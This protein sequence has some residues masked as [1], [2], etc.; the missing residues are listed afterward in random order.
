MLKGFLDR[1]TTP[2]GFTVS[3]GKKR[4][5]P[6]KG[7]EVS[8]L[9][10]DWIVSPIT[11]D[12]A[13]RQGGIRLRARARDLARNNSHIKQFLSLLAANVI[14]P[15]G[16]RLQA[17]VKNNNKE[18]LKPINDKIE[19]AWIDWSFRPTTDKRGTLKKLSRLLIKTLAKDGEVFVRMV[20]GFEGNKYLFALQPIDASQIDYEFNRPARP[21]H[22]EIRL[23]IEVDAWGAAVAYHIATT[24]EPDNLMRRFERIP[25]DKI[26]HIYDPEEI[27]QTRG[28]TWLNS[29]M[30]PIKMLEG[31]AEAELVA[32]R[33]AA[34]KM[35]FIQSKSGEEGEFVAPGPEEESAEPVE[36]EL[37]ASPGVI[38]QLPPGLEFQ[39]W[40]PTHPTSAFSE[41]MKGQLRMM[42]SGLHTSYNALASDLEGVNFSSLRSGLLIERDIWKTI[43]DWWSDEFLSIVYAKWL[44]AA[45]L[46][47][48]LVLDSRD[49]KKFL[50]VK[51]LPRG[52]PWVD[53]LKDVQANILAV[54]NGL[55][56]RTELL[57]EK[58]ADIEDVLTDI[59]HENELAESMGIS[60]TA[61]A[62][63]PSASPDKE[64]ETEPDDEGRTV[65]PNGQGAVAGNHGG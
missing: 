51:W 18:L 12:A 47:G 38:E 58:G 52:W 4:S 19:A 36:T 24:I 15:K 40:D 35:G 54:Q 28:V 43:Q 33:T 30:L 8:R 45:L 62:A 42:A 13:I 1:I 41:F 14:G 56:S 21:G 5:L 46:S 20:R 10:Y 50:A 49:F 29:V 57:A 22:N 25:A 34:A 53:P 64:S 37:E 26:I 27:N 55:S 11:A 65:K 16:I 7:A 23:G 61:S 2:L 44:E 6:Y 59:K 63:K 32:A 31:Y 17:Q 60:I 39:A 3:W 9:N 48:A